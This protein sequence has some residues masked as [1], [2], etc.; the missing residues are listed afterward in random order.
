MTA[1]GFVYVFYELFKELKKVLAHHKYEKIKYRTAT[2]LA[3]ISI[4]ASGRFF[5]YGVIGLTNMM[6]DEN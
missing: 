3:L 2:Y 4:L 6:M 1:C 5:Y